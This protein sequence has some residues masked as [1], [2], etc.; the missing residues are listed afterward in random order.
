MTSLSVS[1]NVTLT[2]MTAIKYQ[3]Y[4]LFQLFVKMAE[5]LLF[6]NNF[7]I[8]ALTHLCTKTLISVHILGQENQIL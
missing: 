3:I 2:A 7:P 1:F 4:N 8:T 5:T 6:P